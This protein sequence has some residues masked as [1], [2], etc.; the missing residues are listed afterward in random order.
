M[1][2]K[3]YLANLAK[4]TRER[5]DES[6]ET[7]SVLKTSVDESLEDELSQLTLEDLLAKLKSGQTT[8]SDLVHAF[9]QRSAKYGGPAGMNAI[10]E[11][12]FDEALEKSKPFA[13]SGYLADGLLRGI[14]ISV[15]DCLGK[16]G[17]LQT[18]GL[19]CRCEEK[20]RSKE[21]S[22]IVD[23]LQRAGA[24]VLVRGKSLWKLCVHRT[25]IMCNNPQ[26][27]FLSA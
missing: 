18:G 22:V 4:E 6:F 21:D 1:S 25:V 26:E 17:A 5:R 10:T 20:Y 23:V 13:E 16:A 11:Q 24:I 9:A 12:F 2:R 3:S 8:S 7:S 15:K 27:T 19:S 14:P